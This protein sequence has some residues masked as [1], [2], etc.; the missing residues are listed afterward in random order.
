MAGSDSAF[1]QRLVI[2]G[3]SLEKMG[4]GSESLLLSASMERT[5]DQATEIAF[6]MYDP[7]WEF[8]RSFG[9]KGPLEKE[10]QYAD[11]K[12]MVASFSVGPG[13]TGEGGS[14]IRLRPYGLEKCRK[15]RGPL[16]RQNL[17]PSQFAA[18][19][20]INCG[21]QWK[22]QDSPPRPSISRDV[23]AD[24]TDAQ[25]DKNEWTTLNRLAAEE[26][27]LVFES[28]NTL[29]FGSPQWLFDTM[30]NHV[31]G[32]GPNSGVQ[33]PADQ[34]LECP[35]I[36]VSLSKDTT[37]E[38]SLRIPLTRVGEINPGHTITVMGVPGELNK[39][40]LL[41]TKIAYPIAGVGDLQIDA[42]DPW[43]IEK[44]KTPEQ[45]AAES[46]A[47]GGSGGAGNGATGPGPDLRNVTTPGSGGLT[48]AATA[49]RKDIM[50]RFGISD[51]GGY[52][53][54]DGYG[55]HS[56]GRALDV[57]VG[58]DRAKGDAVKNYC[59][60]NAV[61]FGLKW[62]IWQQAMW[63]PGGRTEGMSDRGSPTQNHRDHVHIFISL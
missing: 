57:M 6:E 9:D 35:T 33:N 20:A 31:L 51:I 59:I 12:L 21:M 8:I 18:D 40:K 13:P 53:P 15:I 61:N 1:F 28:A 41:V 5:V 4:I 47:S 44:Q 46:A 56:T 3:G 45:Q 37:N 42:R 26:G 43:V 50:A 7:N 48:P 58:T 10:A 25:N 63:Y 49:L 16:T 19:S 2:A 30:P 32:Y 54:A 11:L 38:I 39:R 17:S 23:S 29:Y 36:D 22:V 55:E 14:T 60:E 62:C 52:R 24:N 34:L 27:F